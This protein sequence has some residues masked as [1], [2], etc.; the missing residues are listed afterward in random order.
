MSTGFV[1]FFL[2]LICSLRIYPCVRYLIHFF[3]FHLVVLVY[4]TFLLHLPACISLI[5]CLFFAHISF[6]LC[7][8]QE[9]NPNAS[10]S[11]VTETAAWERFLSNNEPPF[12]SWALPLPR[13]LLNC[14][15]H[16]LIFPAI[17]T[18]GCRRQT[19]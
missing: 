2:S 15:L 6:V 1:F 12:A 18:F 17:L 5:L 13:V 14:S 19:C 10:P 8:S 3:A 4:F 16:K 7:I 9:A 11:A